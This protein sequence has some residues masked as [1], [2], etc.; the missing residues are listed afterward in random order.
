MTAERKKILIVDD[1]PDVREFVQGVLEEGGYQFITAAD[2]EEGLAKA[3]AESPD[4]A[5]LDVQM[6]KKDGFRLFSELRADDA[7]KS[8][9][10]IMLTGIGD[11]T[12]LKFDAEDM[13]EFLGS[14]P[15]AYIEKPIDP[16]KLSE[17]VGKLISGRSSSAK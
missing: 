15:E 9:P 7:T 1:E 14:E 3:K 17:T 5:I 2:G 8:M 16:E 4:L 10:V 13:G 6:P 12:G 11:R